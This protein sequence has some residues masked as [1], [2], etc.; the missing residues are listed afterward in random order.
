M[1]LEKEPALVDSCGAIKNFL[2]S[3]G[4]DLVNEQ[5]ENIAMKVHYLSFLIQLVHS[6]GI[7]PVL[8]R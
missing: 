7:S 4:T 6:N 5:R 3:L 2:D 8:S 1:E